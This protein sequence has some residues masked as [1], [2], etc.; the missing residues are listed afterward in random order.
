MGNASV[1]RAARSVSGK[2]AFSVAEIGEAFLLVE[3]ERIVNRRP[4]FAFGQMFA[5]SIA[6]GCADDILMI[7]VMIR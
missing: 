6:H 1:S 5:Q 7:N 4:D 3:P 2:I